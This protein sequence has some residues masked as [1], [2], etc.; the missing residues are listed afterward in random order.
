MTMNENLSEKI[1]RTEK[2]LS[3][4]TLRLQRFNQEYQQFLEE[5]ALTPDEL[6]SVIEN[7][8]NFSSSALE[9]L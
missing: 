7:Q 1:H 2:K 9:L 6:A 3:E 5:C 8:S 4:L